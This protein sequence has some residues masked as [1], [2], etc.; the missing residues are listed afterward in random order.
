MEPTWYVLWYV[1]GLTLTLGFSSG[2]LPFT[3][4]W[5]PW[6]D[7]CVKLFSPSLVPCLIPL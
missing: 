4:I 3:L 5:R 7:G 6:G 2:Y 1:N